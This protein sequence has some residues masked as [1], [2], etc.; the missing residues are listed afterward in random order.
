M[1]CKI[2]NNRR[3]FL[4]SSA[5][6]LAGVT[7]N[8]VNA[9]SVTGHSVTGKSTTGKSVTGEASLKISTTP[10]IIS[11]WSFAIEANKPAWE[12]LSLK[13]NGLAKKHRKPDILMIMVDELGFCELSF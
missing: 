9:L 8:T 6:L 12:I 7:S 10:K 3:N 2:M 13:F 1:E 5:A 4:K 11:T